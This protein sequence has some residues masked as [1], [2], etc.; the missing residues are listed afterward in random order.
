MLFNTLFSLTAFVPVAL[1][2]EIML[3]EPSFTGSDANNCQAG[4]TTVSGTAS[5]CI[6]DLAAINIQGAQVISESQACFRDVD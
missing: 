4:G 5:T 6:K 3:Y 2:W 1:A